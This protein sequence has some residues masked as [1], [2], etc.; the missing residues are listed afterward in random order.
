MK[1]K[2][3]TIG[4]E[5]IDV[6][7]T[8]TEARAAAEEHLEPGGEW[9][10]GTGRTCYGAFVPIGWAREVNRRPDPSGE[11]DHLCEYELVEADEFAT[12][13]DRLISAEAE[14]MGLRRKLAAMTSLNDAFRP[15]VACATPTAEDEEIANATPLSASDVAR[16]RVALRGRGDVKAFIVRAYDLGHDPVVLASVAVEEGL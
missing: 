6:F 14:V 5:D 2:W 11:F 9:L 10:E 3:I 4:P 8:I 12:L 16:V 7:D 15:V 13:R 1:T